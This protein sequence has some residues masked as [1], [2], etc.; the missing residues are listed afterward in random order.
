[1]RLTPFACMLIAATLMAQEAPPPPG[2]S[3]ANQDDRRAV[4]IPA[5]TKVP[6]RLEHAISTKNA[7]PGQ[8]VYART[9]FPVAINDRIIIPAGT[10]VQ[11]EVMDSKRGG[12]VH[13]KAELLV[14]FRTMIY[15]NGYTVSL[16]GAVDSAPDADST[17]VSGQEGKVEADSDTGKKVGTAAKTA[18]TGAIIGGIAD[19][20]VKGAAIGGGVGAAVGTAIALLTRGADVRLEPGSTLEMVFER[21]V[22]LDAGKLGTQYAATP[23]A[24]GEPRMQR[25]PPR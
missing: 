19:R 4:V 18:G 15:P 21:S 8:G 12:R 3:P 2:E 6:L 11:G 25:R 9:S 23:G 14:H 1:M 16:P 22:T 13:G 17:K 20:S 5:G 10:Y 24:P 7:R